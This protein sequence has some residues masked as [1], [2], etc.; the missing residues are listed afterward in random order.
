MLK[1][2]NFRGGPK[3]HIDLLK[4]IQT[5]QKL[6]QKTLSSCLKELAIHEAIKLKSI[7]PQPKWYSLHRKDGM[8]TDFNSIFL[9][10]GP[11]IKS[12]SDGLSLLFLTSADEIS[13]KGNM[14]LVGD[15]SVISDLGEK[16]CELLEGKGRGKGQRFQAKVNNLKKISAC[17]KLI[18]EYFNR[19]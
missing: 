11:E 3:S 10:N 9:K 8:D 15:E 13:E 19:K 14:I 6:S 12:S 4:K 16:I 7:D 2:W 17:E 18:D 5:T 1:F